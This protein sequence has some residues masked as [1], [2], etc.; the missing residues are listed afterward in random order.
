MHTSIRGATRVTRA[1]LVLAW[2]AL[3]GACADDVAAPT[4]P[5]ALAPRLAIGDVITVTTAADGPD[6]TGSL[7]WAVKQATG[8]ETIRFAPELAGATITLDSALVVYK[9][10]LTIEGP[11]DKGITINGGGKGRVMA[12]N[13]YD[14]SGVT[15]TTLRN[16]TI[17]GGRLV[18][19]GSGLSVGSPLVLDHVTVSGNDSP[20]AVIDQGGYVPS[21]V[22][23]VNSTVSGNA[24]GVSRVISTSGDLTLI[25]STVAE[26]AAQGGVFTGAGSKLT[27]RNS[28]V[29]HNGG[30]SCEVGIATVYAEGMNIADDASCGDPAVTMVTDP[31]LEP[32]AVQGGPAMTHALARTSPAVNAGKDCTVAVDQRYQ[33]RDTQCDIGAYELQPTAVVLTIDGTS[34]VN[35]STGS[36]VVSGTITC[37]REETLKLAVSLRQEQRARRAPAVVQAAGTTSTACSAT[38]RPWSIAIAPASS[39]FTIGAATAVA[40]TVDTPTWVAPSTVTGPVT[41]YWA[42]K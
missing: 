32:L 17:T 11:A 14:G 3:A 35:P 38:T 34:T 40:K 36:A 25:N 8:G 27:V 5:P 31:Q 23:L 12:V 4:R 20:G 18:T 28:I 42:R 33:P 16:L 9:P 6:L 24:S 21:F 7:R 37:S 30:K 19:D 10:L 41:L 15:L 22:T 1:V 2:G 26:N 39:A 13:T 29:S